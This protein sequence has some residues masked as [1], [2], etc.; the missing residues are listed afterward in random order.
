MRGPRSRYA[1]FYS[2]L[3][4]KGYLAISPELTGGS[5]QLSYGRIFHDDLTGIGTTNVKNERKYT[6]KSLASRFFASPIR[7]YNDVFLRA[8]FKTLGFGVN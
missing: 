5:E 4:V 6:H 2:V 7:R 3:T 8:I 1:A